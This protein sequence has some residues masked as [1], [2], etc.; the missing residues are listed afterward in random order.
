M[1]MNRKPLEGLRVLDFTHQVAG[2]YCTMLLGDMGADVIK[3]A[4]PN[5]LEEARQYP[6]FGISVYLA[7]NRNKRSIIVNAK[8]EEGKTILQKLAAQSDIF[9]E[10][11]SPGVTSK[12]GV[13]YATLSKINP[14]LIYCSISGFGSTGPYKHRTG[15]DPMVQ[16]MSGIMS[17]TGEPGGNPVRCGVSLTDMSAGLYGAYAITL[18]LIAR[19]TTGRGQFVETSLYDTAVSF[20]TYWLTNYDLTG[21]MPVKV[22]SG[23]PPFCPYQVFKTS[24]G[25]VFIGVNN[26]SSWN[27]F[28]KVLDLQT[29]GDDDRF[30]TNA[31]RVSNKKE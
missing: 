26:E 1:M 30:K 22:G 18:A 27:S 6:F 28:L 16:A 13:D 2:P 20:M 29:L 14:K 31:L 3:V 10:N 19:A 21:V 15:W 8:T 17:V 25:M 5:C 24:D 7:F 11:F 9:V 4:P 12:L 23:W